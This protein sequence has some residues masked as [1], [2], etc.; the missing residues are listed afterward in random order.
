M[1][2]IVSHVKTIR[3]S[4]N[5]LLQTVE[6]VRVAGDRDSE[7]YEINNL[8]TMVCIA[9]RS[10]SPNGMFGVVHECANRSFLMCESF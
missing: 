4:E 8:R 6:K 9:C 10:I 7:L 3:V 2:I 5:K 1:S